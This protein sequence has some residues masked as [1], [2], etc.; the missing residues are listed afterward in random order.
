VVPTHLILSR[1]AFEKRGHENG[2][3]SLRRWKAICVERSIRSSATAKAM[4]VVC[5]VAALLA[6]G[7][8]LGEESESGTGSSTDYIV[9]YILGLQAFERGQFEEAAGSLEQALAEG[10]WTPQQEAE[11]L[12]IL[13]DC[14]SSLSEY[15]KAIERYSLSIEVYLYY[16]SFDT[17][18]IFHGLV[19]ERVYVNSLNGLGVVYMELGDPAR[20]IGYFEDMLSYVIDESLQKGIALNNLGIC[21]FKT[22]RASR[23]IEFFDEAVT[24]FR[25]VRSQYGEANALTNLGNAYTEWR[26]PAGYARA[27]GC[28]EDSLAI[29][30]AMDDRSG[31]ASALAGLGLLYYL[32]GDNDTSIERY[33]EALSLAA[34]PADLELQWRAHRGIARSKRNL[35]EL[36]EAAEHYRQSVVLVEAIRSSVE[37]EV[38]RQSYLESVRDLFE[39]YL[40]LLWEL[41]DEEE[42]L[43]YAERSRARSLL[44]LF[45]LGGVAVGEAFEGMSVAGTVDSSA[46][47]D[48]VQTS[49]DL[50]GEDEVVL[51]Y[52]WGTQH[53]FSWTVTRSGGIQGP[54]AQEVDFDEALERIYAFRSRLEASA[55]RDAVLRDLAWLHDL[56]I[57]PVA[58]RIEGY[59]T[60]VVVPS[61]PLWYVPYAALRADATGSYV[62]EEHVIA[63]APSVASLSTTL[64]KSEDT[65]SNQTLALTNP[66]RDDMPSLPSALSAAMQRFVLATGGGSTYAEEQATEELFRE[67]TSMAGQMPRY[68]YI[69]LACHG[70]FRYGNPLYSYLALAPTEGVEGNLEAREVLGLELEGTELV[71]LAA[72]ETFLTAVESREDTAGV[73]HEIGEREK[74]DILRDLMRGDELVGLSRSFLLAGAGSVLATQWELYVPMAQTFL[75]RFGEKLEEGLPKGQ[76]LQ[77]ALCDI[78]TENAYFSTD[79]WIWAPFLLV[80]DWR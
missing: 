54:Y 4:A 45:E 12:G 42:M 27:V 5:V 22:N 44:D 10:W 16:Q 6:A 79:P 50:L 31:E 66:H 67:M 33:S 60:W 78:L 26:S 30:R 41:G 21:Y 46:I 8:A 1:I 80:G 72:C 65:T 38:L 71:F 40:E 39:E 32:L 61:G 35:G 59:G 77:Q 14:Y 28:Y 19:D 36:Q 47:W 37:S 64:G 74:L 73:G 13:G 48:L 15:Q 53:L 2:A 17:S 55:D 57:G 9:L 11:T 20:A 75:P 58:G 52:G 49:P 63:Y 56:L 70:V 62:V 43:W 34:T 23:A 3:A 24:V 51:A 18:H 7:S 25:A 68:S 69:A 76:A 29:Q